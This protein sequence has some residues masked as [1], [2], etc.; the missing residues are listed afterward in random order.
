MGGYR[1][2]QFREEGF[3]SERS[4]SYCMQWLWHEVVKVCLAALAG[5]FLDSGQSENKKSLHTTSSLF[6][7][8]HLEAET[9]FIHR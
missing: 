2:P 3:K 7:T 9:P 8:L 4:Y 6:Y 5:Y 1:Y